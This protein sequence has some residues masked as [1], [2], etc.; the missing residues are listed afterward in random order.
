MKLTEFLSPLTIRYAVEVSSKKRALELVGKIAAEHLNT[1]FSCENEQDGICPVECF[2]NLFKREKLGS[3]GINNGV[4]LPHAKLP[5]SD[6]V[7]EKPLAIF[8]QLAEPID[9][10]STDNKDVDLVYA[11]LF[12]EQS[13][14]QYK[15]CLPQIAQKLSDKGLLKLLRSAESVDDIW[16]ILLSAD[17]R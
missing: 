11:L 9:Y 5:Q 17:N 16:Q 15:S 8:L 3:T 4:A 13:C 14:E 7:L 12:S 1:Q 10:E 2:S 6:I